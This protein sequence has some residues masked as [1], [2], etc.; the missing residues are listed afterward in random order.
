M[1]LYLL[2]FVLFL[3]Q[4]PVSSGAAL[5]EAYQY[6]YNPWA[7]HG[8][9]VLATVLDIVV[10]YALGFWLHEKLSTNRIMRIFLGWSRSVSAAAGAYSDYLFLFI[11]GPVIFPTSTLIAPWLNIPFW[12]TLVC[13]FLGDLLFWYGSEWLIVLGVK[14]II[15]DPIAALYGVVIIVLLITAGLRHLGHKER[16]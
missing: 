15:P 6:H 3:V 11:L 7:V 13:M 14:T 12:K 2:L 8:L 1:P 5:L 9:F 4:E 16:V 10:G